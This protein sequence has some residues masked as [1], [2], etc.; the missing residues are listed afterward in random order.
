MIKSTIVKPS[1][2]WLTVNRKCN[3]RC[4]WCYAEGK[5][6]S[7]KDE[8]SIEMA[9]EFVDILHSLKVQTIIII[10]GEPTL[11]PH[12]AE[13]NRYCRKRNIKTSLVT[14]AAR[15]GD[16]CY[17]ERYLQ[18]P[19][20]L[21]GISIKGGTPQQLLKI[22][23]VRNFET[24][25]KGILRAI[26][27]YKTGVSTVYSTLIETSLIEITKFAHACNARF[28]K[29]E[30]CSTVFSEGK[31]LGR[32]MVE[33][34]SV[35]RNIIRD[36][37]ALEKLMGSEVSFE[38]NMP[39]CLWPESFIKQLV[40]NGQIFSVC[41]I[42][43][44]SGIIFDVDGRII[45]CNGLFD[46]PIGQLGVDFTGHKSLVEYINQPKI[47]AYYDQLSRMPTQSCISCKW[48]SSCGGGCP[49]NWA[50]YNPV[51]L[52]KPIEIKGGDCNG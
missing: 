4:Q 11:W 17:W 20:D 49:L 18:N 50:I 6:Y 32:F 44:R 24:V 43:K 25:K 33:P 47:N 28:L 35:V 31:P 34:K 27:H 7:T 23:R 41:H 14:N 1:I 52:I 46:Y 38:M 9:K 48:Y 30:F 13:L 45:V 22:A 29:L 8:M 10:G 3:F 16:D 15:F 42:Y 21:V 26:E 40:E 2:A 51:D 19:C 36:Y 37:P 5:Q 39:F 12:L